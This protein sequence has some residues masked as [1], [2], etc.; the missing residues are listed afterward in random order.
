M[1]RFGVRLGIDVGRSRIG[2]ARCD[3][4]GLLA[5]PI[6]TVTRSSGEDAS[7]VARI[8]ALAAEHAAVV[9]V[10]G[11]PLSLSG[12]ETAST[13]DAREFAQLLA[14]AIPAPVRLVD[15][16]LSTVTAQEALQ[17]SG[18]STRGSR[19]V[20]DQVAAVV[21]LQ[22]AIDSERSSGMSA[23]IALE[24]NEGPLRD[25]RPSESPRRPRRRAHTVGTAPEPESF[26]RCE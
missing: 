15:E 12:T 14:A 2:V 9:I 26:R 3:P 5:V 24:P 8:A 20:I 22:H 10:V 17:R 6:E 23:G 19:A 18:R 16:R 4:D 25:Q 13:H 1:Q 21:I 7:D 11:L